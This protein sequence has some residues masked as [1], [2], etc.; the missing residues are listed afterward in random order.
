MW[1]WQPELYFAAGRTPASRY[2]GGVT[3]GRA[4]VFEDLQDPRLSMVLKPPAPNWHD[5]ELSALRDR[6]DL[7]HHPDLAELLRTRGFVLRAG[8][9]ELDGWT[10]WGPAPR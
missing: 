1:G 10:A 3:A 7:S 6:W 8:P 2:V 5:D 9:K 4:E